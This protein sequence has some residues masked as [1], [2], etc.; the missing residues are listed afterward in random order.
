[1]P[2]ATKLRIPSRHAPALAKFLTLPPEE[3]AMLL[4]A[5]R[6]GGP[7]SDISGLV[8]IIA[9]KLSIERG[10]VGEIIDVLI[11]L[12]GA[13]EDLG[14]SVTDFV[15]TLRS[16]LESSDHGDLKRLTPDWESFSKTVSA[17][18]ADDTALAVSAKAADVMTEH[19]KQ[20]CTARVLTDLRPVFHGEIRKN[21]PLFVT[22]HTLKV[23][24]H[25]NG[26]HLEI[27]I[28]LDRDDLEQLG[29][30]ADRAIQKEDSL[31][32]LASDKGLKTLKETAS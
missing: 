1:M 7:S 13:R 22:V 14:L 17:A 21:E 9:G 12:Q 15:S 11:S 23:V 30:I 19:A 24:Y 31:K 20:F 4:K 29:K 2:A 28:A 25:E 18:L 16:A 26:Q 3:T 10:R 6:E 5:I 27:F 8:E 32:E